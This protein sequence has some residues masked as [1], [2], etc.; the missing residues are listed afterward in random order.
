MKTLTRPALRA[1]LL[2]ASTAALV[3]AAC[4]GD[5]TGHTGDHDE[6]AAEAAVGSLRLHQP[7]ARST[8]MSDTAAMYVHIENTG[9]TDDALVGA[10]SDVAS[11]VELHEAVVSGTSMTMRPVERIAILARGAASLRPGGYHVMMMGLKRALVVDETISVTLVFEKAGSVTLQV[12]V[13]AFV[14]EP[15][16]TATP[17]G[18]GMPTAA[19]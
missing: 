19:P 2:I 8:G 6:T 1:I 10:S 7:Y 5:S 18:M 13:K 3:S 17:D 12:P 15:T 9:D 14:P 11:M 16:A 4:G